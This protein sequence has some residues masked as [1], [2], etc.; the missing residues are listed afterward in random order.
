MG[1]GATK[2][3][4]TQLDK[5]VTILGSTRAF[6]WPFLESTG[7]LIQ[8]Y[9]EEDESVVPSKDGAALALNDAAESF[10]PYMH[11]GGVH[12]YHFEAGLGQHLVGADAANLSQFASTD[13][14]FSL[15]C[16]FYIDS[17]TGTLIAKYDVAGTAREYKLDFAAGPDLRFV[18]RD[19]SQA[20]EEGVQTTAA[21]NTRQW[22]L[23]IAT[24]SGVGGEPGVGAG[25]GVILY[26]D[27]A[28]VTDSDIDDNGYVDMED[29]GCPLMIG[30]TDDQA[31]PASE[32]TGRIAL[33]FICGKQLS[34]AEVTTLYGIGKVLL[35]V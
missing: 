33:P 35:G 28:A 8:S 11:P 15:G 19:E 29:L 3:T 16:F 25:Q 2:K 17:G 18:M 6:F 14:A 7:V 26:V 10:E 30:A 31:A 13:A 1:L 27:G 34:A 21:L 4:F 32:F 22:Y 9:K 23:G 24:Y 12:S 20:K 5:I